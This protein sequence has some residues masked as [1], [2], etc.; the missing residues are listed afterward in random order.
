MIGISTKTYDINGARLFTETDPGKDAA[1]RSGSRR[2]T[3][4]ATLDGG[5]SLCDLGYSHADRIITVV[6]PQASLESIEYARYICETYS[7]VIVSTEDGV[8][9]AGPETHDVSD[10]GELTITLLVKQKLSA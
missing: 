6:E 8:Y 3:R 7:L 5:A 9:E 1:N 10:D 2:L 4:R